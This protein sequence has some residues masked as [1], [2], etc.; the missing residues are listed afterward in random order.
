MPFAEEVSDPQPGVNSWPKPE[1]SENIN[2]TETGN[3]GL[4][5]TDE[6]AIVA[7]LK[8][9]SDGYIIKDKE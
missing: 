7:F 6:S 1:V 9:L 8:T 2:K 3:L 4:G 5:A